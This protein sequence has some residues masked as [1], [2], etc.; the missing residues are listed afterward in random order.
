MNDLFSSLDWIDT[1]L[2][3]MVEFVT[4]W[5]GIN[6]GSHHLPGLEHF[7]ITLATEFG[8]L[9]G[10]ME[11]IDLPAQEIID[12]NGRI[13]CKKLGR[14]IRITKRTSAP[15]QVLLAIHYDTVF[16]ADHH[17]QTAT[18][19]DSNTLRGPGV[20]DAKGGLVVL[21]HALLALERSDLAT[22]LGWEI[23]LTPDEEIGSPGSS[24]LFTQAAERNDVGLVFEPALPDG[25][26]VGARKGSGNFT[27]IVTGR[28]AHAGRNP[29]MGRNAILALADFIVRVHAMPALFPGVT[30][31]V[32]HIEGGGPVNIVPDLAIARFNIRADS[33]DQQH[34]A[35]TR[36][37]HILTEINSQEGITLKLHGCFTA[38]P[39]LL[40]PATVQLFEQFRECGRELKL[41]LDWH[42]AGGVC[43]GNRL[44]A[45][46][47]PTIDT[48]GPRG[49]NLHSDTEY[50]LLDSLT[51]R[52]KLTA[53]FL[54]KY[55]A[56][57]MTAATP[58][59]LRKGQS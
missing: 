58:R 11:M 25:S 50:L 42:P 16:A 35:E 21:L 28:A 18:M 23:L 34:L 44:A 54:L 2:A 22:K 48:L 55:A 17:F 3:R 37:Q 31:N 59:H 49:G 20:A 46:G 53:L 14:A 9:G 45:A 51:E 57:E 15:C 26:L 33:L 56:G 12:G 39:K 19:L 43:D 10:A 27:A 41:A 32:G 5:S 7:A 38:P 1:Q 47:L 30:V 29:E 52:A 6:T 8:P 40:D 4:T 24:E 36:L 13:A